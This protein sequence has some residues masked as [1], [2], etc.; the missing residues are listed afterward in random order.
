M[1]TQFSPKSPEPA[2][3]PASCESIS[4]LTSDDKDEEQSGHACC[5]VEQDAHVV[6]KLVRVVNVGYQDR[7]DEDPKGNSKL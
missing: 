1:F 6:G 4:A 5:Y 2:C 7:R 3:L